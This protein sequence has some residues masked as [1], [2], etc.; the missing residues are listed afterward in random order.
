MRAPWAACAGVLTS[1]RRAPTVLTAL[2]RPAANALAA[3][4]DKNWRVKVSDFNLSKILQDTP[5]L[6]SAQ[7]LNPR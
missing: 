5:M 3:V 4:V 1:A 6:S 7:A 2:P